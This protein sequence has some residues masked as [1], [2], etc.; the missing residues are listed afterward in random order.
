MSCNR[1]EQ[2]CTIN[3][4][5]AYHCT[6]KET[7]MRTTFSVK[8]N[9][10]TTAHSAI[11][12]F[13]PGYPE[14]HPGFAL[15]NL[16]IICEDELEE[17]HEMYDNNSFIKTELARAIKRM[18][19]PV[20][21]SPLQHLINHLGGAITAWENGEINDSALE[22]QIVTSANWITEQDEEEE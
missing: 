22:S 1:C 2:L 14:H 20:R 12:L 3:H 10:V 16:A 11:K 5:N 18:L 7:I 13:L 17:L 8:I 6:K 21:L 9:H 4:H 19:E 15:V